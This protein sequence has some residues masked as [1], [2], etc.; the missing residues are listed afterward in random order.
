M[1]YL[2][3]YDRNTS[4][5]TSLETFANDHAD[6]AFEKRLV[7]ELNHAEN[8]TVEVA[9]LQSEDFAVLRRTHARYF[10]TVEELVDDVRRATSYR[11][12]A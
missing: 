12:P 3:V 8:N 6:E 10:S 7:Y 4:T 9:L 1:F 2:I 5:R 11:K